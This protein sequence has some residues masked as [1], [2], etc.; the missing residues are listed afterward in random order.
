VGASRLHGP[1]GHYHLSVASFGRKASNSWILVISRRLRVSTASL[2][3]GTISLIAGTTTSQ[4]LLPGRADTPEHADEPA[5]VTVL[6]LSWFVETGGSAG[7]SPHRSTRGRPVAHALVTL[8]RLDPPLES[9]NL[10]RG[11]DR[12]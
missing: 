7:S 4:I 9:V 6:V 1:A 3:V 5:R 11:T 10:G 8:E 2:T 12:R